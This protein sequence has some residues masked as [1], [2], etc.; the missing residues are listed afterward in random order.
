MVMF[1]AARGIGSVALIAAMLLIWP[2][3]PALAEDEPA[4]RLGEP[5][6]RVLS[7]DGPNEAKH[8]AFTRKLSKGGLVFADDRIE[9]GE[10]AHL[11]LTMLNG[12]IIDLG[13]Q[14]ALRI[15]GEEDPFRLMLERGPVQIDQIEEPS[16]P[17]IVNLPLGS[18]RA[19]NARFWIGAL[20][21]A[22][23]VVAWEGAVTVNT[24]GGSL[25]LD[26]EAAAIK[27]REANAPLPLPV[28]LL[29]RKLEAVRASVAL[30]PPDPW[31]Q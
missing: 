17:A 9:L 6:G 25:T 4:P 8:P 12:S 7:T 15:T 3:L 2:W 24:L 1:F 20:D 14:A 19:E 28:R 31:E 27:L 21:A 10:G 13:A 16:P 11:R 5:L 18:V 22:L 23:T 29:E 26:E 30:P